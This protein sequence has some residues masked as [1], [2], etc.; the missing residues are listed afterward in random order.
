MIQHRLAIDVGNT[1]VKLGLFAWPSSRTRGELPACVERTSLL[2]DEPLPWELLA[3]WQSATTNWLPAAI[4]G[5]NPVG[6]ER[7][8]SVWPSSLGP[9]PQ[10]IVNT[11][12]FPLPIRVDEPRRVGIDRLLNAVA[13]NE[14]RS[15]NH[16]AVIVDS[17]T[18]TTVDVVSA[19]GVRGWGDSA[20]AG[21]VSESV[22]RI[23]KRCCRSS[24]SQNLGKRLQNLLAATRA[25]RFAA[26]CS[27]GNSVLSKN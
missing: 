11:D 25:R 17:G 14:L 12:D 21:T 15:A 9:V 13:V 24:R 16:S 22:A 6:V 8:K 19:D 4:A 3:Q 20:G 27:G 7:I 26:D 5:S 1:R 2:A 10:T 23:H 18:A